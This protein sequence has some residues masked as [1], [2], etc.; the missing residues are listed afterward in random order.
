[1]QVLYYVSPKRY[2]GAIRKKGLIPQIGFRS[3]QIGETS[4]AVY[5]FPDIIA[6]E[7]A[8]MNWLGD[9]F[10]EEAL[11]CWEVMIPDEFPIEDGEAGYEKI[12]RTVIPPEYLTI[13]KIEK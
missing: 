1:M 9:C 12:S 13:L 4:P 5:L 10:E 8:V 2:A 3:K 11:V 6:M 7:E